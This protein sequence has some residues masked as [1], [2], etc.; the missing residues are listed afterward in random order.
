MLITTNIDNRE[1]FF[2]NNVNNRENFSLI[3]VKIF[4][5]KNVDNREKFLLKTTKKI[6]EKKNV[7]RRENIFVYNREICIK[8]LAFKIAFKIQCNVDSFWSQRTDKK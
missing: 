4:F 6:F 2:W 1:K 8:S 5:E 3:T 7:Y